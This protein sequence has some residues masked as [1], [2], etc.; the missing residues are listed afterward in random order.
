MWS[1][2]GI[3][4]GDQNVNKQLKDEF[5]MVT[6]VQ[7]DKW[8]ENEVYRKIKKSGKRSYSIQVEDSH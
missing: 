8:K 3:S 4:Y 6:I 5:L 2:L 1:K 7:R